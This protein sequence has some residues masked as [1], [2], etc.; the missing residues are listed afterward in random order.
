MSHR[1]RNRNRLLAQKTLQIP[2]I[3]FPPRIR[4]I[5]FPDNPFYVEFCVNREISNIEWLN[6][7]RPYCGLRYPPDMRRRPLDVTKQL[8]SWLLTVPGVEHL[9]FDPYRIGISLC[10]AVEWDEVLWHLIEGIGEIVYGRNLSQLLVDKYT[11][12]DQDGQSVNSQ[13]LP[14]RPSGPD[15]LPPS[16]R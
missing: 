10:P 16:I 9:G 7:S 5:F 13:N 1:Q 2:T 12:L 3:S 4:M 14:N 15:E 8:A 11:E 6:I